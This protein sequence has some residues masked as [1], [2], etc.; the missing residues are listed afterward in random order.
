MGK[1][2]IPS[3]ADSVVEVGT[4]GIWTYRKW[5]SGIAECW[6]TV[7]V[8]SRTYAANGGYYNVG[9]TYPP[10]LFNNSPT[11]VEVSGGLTSTV[12][13]DIGFTG[14]NNASSGQTY[15]INRNSGAV[16]ATGWVFVHVIGRWK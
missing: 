3:K 10:N 15:L 14:N 9:F 1:T 16:T 13:T 5:N 12:N 8:A 2:T 7:N 6:G 4:E 11:C